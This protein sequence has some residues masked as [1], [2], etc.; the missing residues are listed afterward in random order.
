[1][2]AGDWSE[3]GA[4]HWFSGGVRYT[5]TVEIDS[6]SGEWTLDLGDVDATCEVSV[7]GSDPQFIINVPYTLDVTSLLKEGENTVSVLVY[8]SLANHCST[9]ASP[10]KGTPRAGLMGPVKLCNHIARF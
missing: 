8:S 1:M 10:Y 6:L 2:K 3:Q 4:M 7:N 9:G 5:K